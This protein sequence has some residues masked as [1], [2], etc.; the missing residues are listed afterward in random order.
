MIGVGQVVTSGTMGEFRIR[1]K[2]VIVQHILPIFDKY[3]LLTSKHFNYD[4]FKKAAL[5]LNNDSLTKE[6][7]NS[8]LTEL[9][10]QEMPSNYVSPA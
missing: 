9:K 1:N 5:I 3:S 10:A 6:Q 2:K 7:K 4:R 8:L